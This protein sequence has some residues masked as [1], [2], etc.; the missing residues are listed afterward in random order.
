MLTM[1]R[2]RIKIFK[3]QMKDKTGL[4]TVFRKKSARFRYGSIKLTALLY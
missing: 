1:G 4:F 2:E 3:F